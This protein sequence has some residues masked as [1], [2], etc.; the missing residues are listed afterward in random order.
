MQISK[1]GSNEVLCNGEGGDLAGIYHTITKR[2]WFY[3]PNNRYD[4]LIYFNRL[5]LNAQISFWILYRPK[6]GR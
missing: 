5:A 1:D 6:E 2:V 4:R 3:N